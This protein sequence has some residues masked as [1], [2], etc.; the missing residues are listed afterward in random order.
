MYGTLYV[1]GNLEE[2][3]ANPEEY[4]AAANLPIKDELLKYNT[5]SHEWTFDELVSDVKT[6]P[7]GRSFEV[8]KQLFKVASCVGCH[9]LDNEGQVFGPDLAKLDP[10]KQTTEHI[11]QSIVDPSKVI[12]EKF[13]SHTFLLASGKII[14]GMIVKDTADEVHVVIDPLAKGKPTVIK[15]D[16]IEDQKKSAVSLM[17]KGL[18]NKLTREEI[19]DLL[20]FV[21]AKGDKKHQMFSHEHHNH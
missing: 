17:P 13:Q 10:K 18:L 16:D 5:R 1:V 15:K 7:M 6:L 14:T 8:G 2:Y 11:L 4:L 9:K 3:Q 12:D 20:A 19:Y 21:Y